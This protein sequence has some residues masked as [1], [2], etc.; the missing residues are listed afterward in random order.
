MALQ[1]KKKKEFILTLSLVFLLL[2][3]IPGQISC[4][5]HYDAFSVMQMLDFVLTFFSIM[6]CCCIG[7]IVKSTG[8]FKN[9]NYLSEKKY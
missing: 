9:L 8:L 2:P 1:K 4:I 7:F 3:L 5:L 6:I